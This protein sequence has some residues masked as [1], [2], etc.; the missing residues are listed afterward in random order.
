MR[1]LPE[2]LKFAAKMYDNT[3]YLLSNDVPILILHIPYI[4]APGEKADT[5][6]AS[7]KTA[8]ATWTSYLA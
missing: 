3:P 6:D 5:E 8:P 1:T 2:R 7:R 4:L